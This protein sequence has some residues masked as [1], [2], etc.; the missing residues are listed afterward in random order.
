MTVRE[1]M[2]QAQIELGK[3]R[4]AE[5]Q[6]AKYSDAV[7]PGGATAS[8]FPVKPGMEREC[9]EGLKTFFRKLDANPGVLDRYLQTELAKRARRN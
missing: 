3:S 6:G 2:I 1:A 9:I 5:E 4:E 7:L 8:G